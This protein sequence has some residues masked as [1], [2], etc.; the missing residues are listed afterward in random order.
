V[1][2]VK[3]LVVGGVGSCRRPLP[4]A[5]SASRPVSARLTLLYPTD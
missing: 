4:D 3:H 2:A 5:W 1:D